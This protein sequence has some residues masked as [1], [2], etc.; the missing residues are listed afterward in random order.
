MFINTYETNVE[1]GNV[2]QFVRI[3]GKIGLR[4]KMSDEWCVTDNLDPVK[5]IWYRTFRIYATKKQ[6]KLIQNELNKIK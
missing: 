4:F 6:L 5:K 2:V 3:L 1:S